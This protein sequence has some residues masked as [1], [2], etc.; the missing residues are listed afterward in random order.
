MDGGDAAAKADGASDASGEATMLDAST[1]A[2]CL[3]SSASA[4]QAPGA[5]L[6]VVD[7]SGRLS[8]GTRW[9][10]V[11]QGVV[12]ALDVDAFDSLSLGVMTFPSGYLPAPGCYAGLVPQVG[13]G[14]PTA[15]QVPIATAGSS[16]STATSGVRHD[17]AQTLTSTTPIQDPAWTAPIYAT[18]G[19]AYSALGAS[20]I[21]RR[22]A[23]LVTEGGAGCATN[24]GRP[25]YSDGSCPDWEEPPSIDLLIGNAQSAPSPTSTF[26]IGLP[27]SNSTGSSDG[28]YSTPPYSA[29]LAL[30]TYAVS[31]SPSTV[32]ATC[33]ST[34]TFAQNGPAPAAPCHFDLSASTTAGDLA[35][36]LRTA[37]ARAFG[38][39]YTLPSSVTNR[40][41]VNVALTTDGTTSQVPRRATPSDRCSSSPCWDYDASGNVD[42]LGAAC[43]AVSAATAVNVEIDVGC[44][45]V[46]K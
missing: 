18:L 9:A 13:C 11:Q 2:S 3:Q 5:L 23:V 34:A 7:A 17:I 19:G 42:I 22:A 24:S 4:M 28:N 1:D 44:P 14:V 16:K 33:D 20:G 36:A 27:G 8:S 41:L 10:I 40:S 45:T 25:G 26:V 21:A 31:G 15:A 6:L 38:C 46:S 37:R 12:Q 32:P 35:T 43:D 39:V 29:L 30:S